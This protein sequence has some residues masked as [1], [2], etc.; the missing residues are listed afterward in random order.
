MQIHKK[1][2]IEGVVSNDDTRENIGK[3]FYDSDNVK[4]PRLVATD[5]RCLA[6]VK[7]DHTDK[8][9]SAG[10]I[11]PLA[12][13]VARKMAGK[14]PMLRFDCHDSAVDVVT[15]HMSATSDKLVEDAVTFS[16]RQTTDDYPHYE[17]I[18]PTGHPDILL[19]LDP[20]ALLAVAKA[21]GSASSVT[22]GVKLPEKQ[23]TPTMF[24]VA[25]CLTVTAK[26][27][28]DAKGYLMPLS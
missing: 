14:E 16:P 11:D 18:I 4:G 25:D 19:S 23:G 28:D 2:R 22:L 27:D 26:D 17:A 8:E 1:Y 6:I 5:G 12:F 7:V 15:T 13:T 3:V 20:E 21:I 9:D 10:P 24:V